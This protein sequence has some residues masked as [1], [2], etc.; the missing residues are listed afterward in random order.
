MALLPR[1]QRHQ[2]LRFNELQYTEGDIANFKTR[3]MECL[4]AEIGG[5][6]LIAGVHWALIS[7]GQFVARLAEHFGLLTEERLQGLTVIATTLP[8]IYMTELVRLQ[9]CVEFGDT[10][11]W[12]PAGPARQEGDVRGVAEEALMTPGGGDEDQEMPYAMSP[13]PRTQDER[14]ARLKEKTVTSLARMM[15][16]AG[17]PY[18]RYSKLPVEYERRNRRRT[19]GVGTSTAPQ[20]PDP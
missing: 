2:Y 16:R 7:G 1:D 19:N 10:W 6:C 15:D 14:I 5:D 4:L 3:D 13:L 8:I 12:V 9:I 20:Q 17:V 11:A 18:T